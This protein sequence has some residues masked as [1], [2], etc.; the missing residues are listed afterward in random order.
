MK[1]LIKGLIRV[2]SLGAMFV[3]APYAFAAGYKMEF[4]STS[5]LA[6][7][8]E[9]AVVEDAGTNWYNSAGLVYLPQQFAFSAIDVYAPTTFSGTAT[10]PAPFTFSA[11]GT[12][13]SH[14]NTVLP[15]IHYAL[16]FKD[17]FAFG[18]S[19]VPAWGF[20]EDYGE[21][22]I[23]R[24][25]LTRIY[26]KTL[27]IAPSFA[28]KI[29]NQWSLGFGPDFH[30][31]S[32][33]SRSH[34]R[35]QPIF[36]TTDS[37]SRFSA[38]SWNYGAHFGVLYNITDRTRVGLNYRTKIVQNLS[39]YSDFVLGAPLG[40]AFETNAF[41]LSIPLPPVTTLSIYHDVNPCWALMGTLAYDQ[42][43]VLHDY[44][45]KNYQSL[46]AIIADVSQPQHMSN[47]IDLSVGTHYKLNQKWMLRGS[48]KY[49]PTPTSD[50]FRGVEFPDGSKLGL[51]IG[52]RYQLNRKI[53]F[54][55][56]YGHVFVKTEGINN[57][58][59]VTGALANGR[60]RTSIDL[61]GAQVVWTI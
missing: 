51:N 34:S 43:S 53:A 42:W 28:W 54:D 27:D 15:G 44:H 8:G 31:F 61:L 13:S 32:V 55:V 7:A 37:I 59:P 19:I 23:I 4:Q 58:N 5:V 14:P 57:L 12:A 24:Y 6:D 40:T 41:K 30:Y 36:S 50:S 21:G 56:I 11:N 3:L 39:G 18:I 52:A 35:T 45:G 29:N 38:N 22:S 20:L 16:P 1:R 26:T 9:A 46:G 10:N 25:N 17:R 2:G 47:T 33:L 49:E 60:Q 48:V